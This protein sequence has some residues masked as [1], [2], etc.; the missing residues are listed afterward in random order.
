MW[1]VLDRIVADQ[2]DLERQE[3]L[4]RA[5]DLGADVVAYS[6]EFLEDGNVTRGHLYALKY[7]GS[8]RPAHTS[9]MHD[10]LH[11][12][13]CMALAGDGTNTIQTGAIEA[14][15]PAVAWKRVATLDGYWAAPIEDSKG[16]GWLAEA[17]RQGAT[18][19][20]YDGNGTWV[21][22]RPVPPARDDVGETQ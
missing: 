5:R 2:I 4:A 19:A 6:E 21:A 11:V 13:H 8:H 1:E 15:Y 16:L 18:V 12:D 14:L 9:P 20:A 3:W 17:K 10:V 22:L 7:R